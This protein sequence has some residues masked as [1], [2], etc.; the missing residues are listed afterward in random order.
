MTYVNDEKSY[1]RNGTD[2]ETGPGGEGVS[3]GNATVRSY[4]TSEGSEGIALTDL[5]RAEPPGVS[6]SS[7]RPFP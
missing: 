2:L 6:G 1:D 7:R 4:K 3:D 5:S